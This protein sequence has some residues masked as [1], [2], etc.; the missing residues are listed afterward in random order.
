LASI[1]PRLAITAVNPPKVVLASASPARLL[2]L[3]NAGI[4]P[5]VHVSH[6]DE[7]AI[8]ASHP[9]IAPKELAQLLAQAKCEEVAE[10]RSPTNGSELIIGC[11]SVFELNGE[12]FGKPESAEVARERWQSMM[13]TTGTLHT[14]HYVISLDDKGRKHTAAGTASTDVTL[15]SLSE[16]EVDAYLASGEPLHVA[17]GFTI[18]SLGGAFVEQVHGDPSNVVGISLPTVR[19]LV[20]ELG[21]T[22]TDLWGQSKGSDSRNL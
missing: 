11:D 3:R 17:G 16:K 10:Q 13:N 2:T 5:V 1:R 7:E 12:P 4:N 6:V 9:D 14:G 8:Q 19:R 15:G 18:D 22:W 21:F 20:T